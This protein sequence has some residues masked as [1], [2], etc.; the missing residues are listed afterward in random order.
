MIHG[1]G[2]IRSPLIASLRIPRGFEINEFPSRA[3]VPALSVRDGALDGRRQTRSTRPQ[4][5]VA[6][7]VPGEG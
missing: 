6:S 2:G 1:L 5:G 4:P 7:L 3:G